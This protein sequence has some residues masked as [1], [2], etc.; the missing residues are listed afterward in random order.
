MSQN[1][2]NDAKVPVTINGQTVYVSSSE[3]QKMLTKLSQNKATIAIENPSPPL[4]WQ[5]K[6]LILE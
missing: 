4:Q 6:S 1:L 2:I 5:G 3:A